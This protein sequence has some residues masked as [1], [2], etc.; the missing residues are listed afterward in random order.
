MQTTPVVER[1]AELATFSRAMRRAAD[2]RGGVIAV[3]GAA[4]IGKTCVLEQVALDAAGAGWLVLAGSAPRVGPDH[5]FLL[6]LLDGLDLGAHPLDGPARALHHLRAGG[7]A[8]ARDVVLGM[9]WLLEDLVAERPVL[10]VA[11]DVDRADP[12]SLQVLHDLRD[13]VRSL[14]CLLVV[15]VT[16]DTPPDPRNAASSA[17]VAQLIADARRVT[18]GPLSRDAIAAALM[19]AWPDATDEEVDLLHRRSLGNPRAVV[20]LLRIRC[21]PRWTA[22]S[23]R[24][25]LGACDRLETEVLRLVCLDDDPPRLDE[26]ADAVH[27]PLP[28]LAALCDR[29]ER[30][31]LLRIDDRRVAPQSSRV[32]AQ[33]LATTSRVEGAELHDRLAQTLLT[34][35]AASARLV[36]HLLHSRSRGNPDVRELLESEGRRALRDGDPRLAAALLRRALDEGVRTPDDAGLVAALAR[37]LSALGDSE[38]SVTCWRR[39]RSMALDE[40][41]ALAY[42]ASAADALADA[43]RRVEAAAAYAEIEATAPPAARRWVHDRMLL[44]GYVSGLEAPGSAPAG[45]SPIAT[46]FALASRSR[47]SAR[48]ATLAHQTTQD[49]VDGRLPPRSLL[50]ATALL[51]ATCPF[52]EAEALLSGA[53][54]AVAPPVRGLATACRGFVRVRAGLVTEGLADLAAVADQP[55]VAGPAQAAAQLAAFI[56]GRLARGDLADATMLADR[57]ARAPVVAGIGAALARHTL[58]EVAS[59]TGDDARAI[60]LYT[61]AGRRLGPDVDNPALLAWRVGAAFA[62][63]RAGSAGRALSLAREN[64]RLAEQFGAAY[65]EAQALRTLAAV[66]VTA[67]RIGLLRR[68]LNLL[69]PVS[70]PRLRALV[71]TD[72]AALLMLTPPGT[73]EA[74]PLLRAADEY[75]TG[76]ELAPLQARARRLL[77][78]LG[79]QP[80]RSRSE[81]LA[82]LTAG[83]RRTA[84]LAAAGRTNQEIADR[85]GVSIK[86]VEWHL[87]GCYRKLG[88][89][90]RR[91]LSSVLHAA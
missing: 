7:T 15:A 75:A 28:E 56:E 65:A 73:D 40:T 21:F 58:A 4:G 42:A 24:A 41:A 23:L 91:Q 44:A 27:Q 85:L 61:E 55:P 60:R 82:S 11:D 2:G 34:R 63:I 30:E 31:R 5:S 43:G 48:V 9:R 78:R 32:R 52:E 70:A 59:A 16:D 39:A 35:G 17:L 83:E 67:D 10:L 25:A 47:A 86:A 14:G 72:L 6:T 90:S 53:L 49:V 3:T 76:Q 19:A 77:E 88:I 71:E 54:A 29:L 18:P 66:D 33:V 68:A 46:A 81:A 8:S 84:R 13:E 38:G 36:P 89:R 87:S 51:A 62:E 12:L 1:E 57:L 37:A 79:E 64:L 20:D 74:V 45:T 26:L 50:L 80:A 22:A 69:G